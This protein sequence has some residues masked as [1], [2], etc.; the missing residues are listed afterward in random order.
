MDVLLLLFSLLV[1]PGLVFMVALAFFTEWF[2][3][4]SVAR[5]QSRMGPAYVGPFGILQPFAD[6]LKLISVKDEIKQKYGSPGIAKVFALLGI[7][8]M[9]ASLL[10]LP[11]S[12][13]R[14]VA[15]Y[16]FLIFIYLCGVWV[17]LS[18]FILAISMPNPFTFLGASRLLSIFVLTEP[19]FF[20]AMLIPVVLTTHIYSESCIAP[21][22]IMFTAA[23]SIWLWSNPL[24]I[25]PMILGLIAV[26]V[27]VQ[28]K[29]MLQP[30][31]IPE[32]EQE[33]IAGFMTEFSGPLLALN[34]LLHD[35]DIAVTAL[36][37]TYLF[38]GGPYPFPHLSL[39]GILTLVIKY[40]V[41]LYVITVIKASF[42]RFRIDQGL[43]TI[44]KYGGIPALIGIILTSLV[45]A[46]T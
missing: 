40:I 9:A 11:L 17:P 18:M 21:Y 15:P 29:S 43:K 42:G 26:M 1:F 30:F 35:L 20:T 31:N 25:I 8:A 37:I 4:K 10:L 23:H 38:L 34:N 16:D 6:F 13:Y 2:I 41:V 14:L 46:L 12:P 32:A 44:L 45:I 22:S 24:T 39:P 28:A 7:G 27:A 5:M 19:I 3:R 33:I 36:F